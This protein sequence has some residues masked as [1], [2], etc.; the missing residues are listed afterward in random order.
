M[1]ESVHSLPAR[2]DGG[3]NEFDSKRT[4]A[5]GGV[6]GEVGLKRARELGDVVGLQNVEKRF[7]RD[8]NSSC[9]DT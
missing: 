5:G 6:V 8:V 3:A 4:G 9:G 2:G 1:I 7:S